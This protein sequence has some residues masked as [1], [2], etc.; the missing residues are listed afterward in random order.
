MKRIIKSIV[1]CIIVYLLALLVTSIL[2]NKENNLEKYKLLQQEQITE[3]F[4]YNDKTYLLTNYHNN[5]DTYASNNILYKNKNDYYLV[6]SINKCDMSYYIDNN[7]IYVHCIGEKGII[8]KYTIIKNEIKK[9]LLELDYSATP[10]ISEI[11]LT[12]D[13]VDKE[14]IY[15][16][17]NV[18]KD[19]SIKEGNSIR[20]YLNNNKCE[21]YNEKQ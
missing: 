2:K 7:N 21:Y 3:E 20:C 1:I 10:N 17:S 19:E 5:K 15:L 18:K 4:S 14:Y 12:I 6:G 11:H 16:K 8:T 9:E 13:K